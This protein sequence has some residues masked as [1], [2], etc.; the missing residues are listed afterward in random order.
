MDKKILRKGYSYIRNGKTVI[1]PPVYIKDLGP[2]G[3]LSEYVEEKKEEMKER[4]SRHSADYEGKELKCKKGK[5]VRKGFV[6]KRKGKEIV[7][8][9]ACIDDVGKPGKGEQLITG[10]EQINFDSVGY[11]HINSLS[12][13]ER[14]NALKKAVEKF[15]PLS[16]FRRLNALYV[17]NKNTN[18]TLSKL[19]LRDRNY[20]KKH[21][22]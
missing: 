22:M 8:E 16:V 17:L 10:I 2:K 21:Y 20:V 5:I 15:T 3:K 19:F 14:R 13:M 1:V 12:L 7:V 9:A 11:K 6:S 18:K 4:K